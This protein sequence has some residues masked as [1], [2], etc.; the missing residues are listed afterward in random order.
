MNFNE[1]ELFGA[2][3]IGFDLIDGPFIKRKKE[4]GTPSNLMN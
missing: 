4:Y 2:A 1:N 3:L